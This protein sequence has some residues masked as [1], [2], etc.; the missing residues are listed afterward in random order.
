MSAIRRVCVFCGSSAGEDPR[1]LDT[2]V[3]MGRILAALD[4]ELVYGGSR[5]GLMGRLADTVLAE[6][7][8]VVGVIPEAL[9]GREVAHR[10]LTEL[11]VVGSMHERKATMERL[12]DAFVALPGGLGTLEELCEILTWAQLGLH[13]KPCGVVD[14]SGYF[15]P[16]IALLDHMVGE[17]FLSRRTRRMLLVESR[18]EPLLRRMREYEAPTVPRWIEDGQT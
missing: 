1:Y 18:P 8:A 10:E 16:L 9:V 2:A 13:R 15:Q 3:E 14:A 17:G 5:I 4:V 11:R 7:G 12:S 6:G